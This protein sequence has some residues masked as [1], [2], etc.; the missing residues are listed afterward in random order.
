M[1]NEVLYMLGVV[2]VGF[3]VNYGLRTLPFLLFA[4][5]RRELPRGV[6][7]FGNL[8]SPVIIAALVV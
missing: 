3:A 7:R 2:A 8:V 1:E 4:G 5:S 6:E